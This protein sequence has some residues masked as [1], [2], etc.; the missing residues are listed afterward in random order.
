MEYTKQPLIVEQQIA[1][2]KQR[3]LVIKDEKSAANYLSNISY[4]RLRAYTFP[5]QD[6]ENL[7][8]DHHFTQNDICFNDIIDLYC[9]DR[10]LR[11]LIFNAL[12][13]IEIALR[14]RFIYGYGTAT[15]NSHWF[16]DKT[17]YF[18]HFD[19]IMEKITEDVNRSDED[20]I[21]HYRQ[22]YTSPDLPPSWMTL[23]TLSFGNLSKLI[24]NLDCKSPIYKRISKSFGLPNPFILENW[25]YSFSVL[26]NYC[27]HHSRIWNRRFHVELKLPYNTAFPFI[28]RE[29]QS[30]IHTNKLFVVLSAIQY[31]IKIISPQSDFK[32]NLL[33]LIKNGGKLLNIRDMGFPEK[34][35]NCDVWK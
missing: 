2:L 10:R 22:K 3:G 7:E 5:F 35:Q 16:T 34:W 32:N 27:A 17:L 26:R 33:D 24:A 14:T 18:D 1:K 15:N 13:K 6:N 20:F 30:K 11:A 4:Y 28:A 12:E 9:F 23:E 21:K 31:V 25:I 29:M 19:F 8:K